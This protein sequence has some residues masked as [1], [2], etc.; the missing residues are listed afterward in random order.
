M[1]SVTSSTTPMS[2]RSTLLVTS[3]TDITAI[4]D[5]TTST[6][7]TTVTVTTDIKFTTDITDMATTTATMV[8]TVTTTSTMVI[9]DTTS[10][11]TST[12]TT[13][14][15]T[16][17]TVALPPSAPFFASDFNENCLNTCIRVGAQAAS[18]GSEFVNSVA[19]MQF[20]VERLNETVSEVCEDGIE[21]SAGAAVPLFELFTP[22]RCL[23]DSSPGNDDAT[24]A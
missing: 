23:F 2:T 14:T 1:L 11:T 9:T 4:T 20:V 24:I 5:T 8:I 17:T 19:R 16:T 6:T 18:N 7:A 10:L 21:G 12:S 22:R 15:T 3:T 13:T